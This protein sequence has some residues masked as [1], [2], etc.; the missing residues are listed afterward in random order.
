MEQR[1][2]IIAVVIS[3]VILVGFQFLVGHFA[4]PPPPPTE[5]QTAPGTEEVEQPPAG[6]APSAPGAAVGG[7]TLVERPAALAQSP[8]V[9]IRSPRLTGSIS[10]EGGRIDDLVLADYKVDVKPGSANVVLLSPKGT[11]DAYWADFG[12]VAAR[13]DG[14]ELPDASTVWQ[15]DSDALTPERPVTLNW[16][17]G[18]GLSFSQTIALDRDYMFTVTQ[19]VEN[20]GG[21]TATLF[22]YGLISR[23]G[24]P[25]LLGFFI[26]HEGL[27]GVLNGTLEEVDYSDLQDEGA[28]SR[29]SA[30]GWVGIT[31]K[32]WLAAMIPDQQQKIEASFAHGAQT[33]TYQA[34]FRGAGMTLAPASAVESQSRFFAGAKEVRLLDRYR[35]T[36][37]IPLFERAVDWGWFWFLTRP[38][39]YVLD[40]IYGALG[41]FGVAIL[42]LTIVIKLLFYPLAN[43]SYRAMSKMKALAPE[44]MKLRDRFKDDRQRLNQEMMGLYKREK[45]NP[46][47]GCLPIVIQIPVFFA[48]YKVLFVTIEM[49]H[50]PFFGWIK[51]LSAPDPTSILNLFGL[52]PYSIPELGPLQ[53][54]SIGIWPII[55]GVTMY[56]QQKLNP[57]PPDP[58]QARIFMML[59]IVFT[60]M[61]AQ[62]PAGLVIYWAWNNILS[63]AQQRA[64]MWRMGVKV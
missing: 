8:R 18:A 10:L 22:P 4:P 2:L 1:N 41:N 62:F 54:V 21:A 58:I 13:G 38:I 5:Q 24:T 32:Y 12:W 25:P 37:G 14:L 59:P 33:D 36:L 60:F 45:V 31:D 44:M 26:L 64:I 42:V 57:T 50:S 63:I 23:F 27:I 48:L 55:M 29:E 6:P 35:D 43:K 11:K 40:E 28:Q 30:G 17:N 34:A 49:R 61:L 16:D 53:L 19:R 20:S 39:F 46:A 7:V 56:L 15:A 9:A 47:S 3:I 51:D 52:L